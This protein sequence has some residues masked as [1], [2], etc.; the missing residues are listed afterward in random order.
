[1]MIPL[2]LSASLKQCLIPG[3][4]MNGFEDKNECTYG[5]TISAGLARAACGPILFYFRRISFAIALFN[6]I[7]WIEVNLLRFE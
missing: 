6:I 4:A 5:K 2:S 1:M 3:M 7:Y